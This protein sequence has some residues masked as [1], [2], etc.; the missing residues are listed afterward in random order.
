MMSASD[1]SGGSKV[2]GLFQSPYFSKSSTGEGSLTPPVLLKPSGKCWR[3]RLR[4]PCWKKSLSS[5]QRLWVK[6]SSLVQISPIFTYSSSGK[7]V[8]FPKT[9]YSRELGYI[10]A[11]PPL[12]NWSK[13]RPSLLV[14]VTPLPA[15][16]LRLNGN[17][18]FVS[19]VPAS[20]Y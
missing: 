18:G 10:S 9:S 11:R 8:S 15:T 12:T 6:Y 7:A 3:S 4:P 13:K 2:D 1:A 16:N 19:S 17:T 20:S 5:P 14:R